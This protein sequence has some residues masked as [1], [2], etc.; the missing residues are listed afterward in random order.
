MYYLDTNRPL[1]FSVELKRVRVSS[2]FNSVFIPYISTAKPFGLVYLS[3][4]KQTRTLV[5]FDLG[6]FE[7]SK[8]YQGYFQSLC[9]WLSY[10]LIRRQSC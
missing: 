1:L 10:F 8:I 6:I 4:D 7:I 3:E 5:S 9:R 2:Q